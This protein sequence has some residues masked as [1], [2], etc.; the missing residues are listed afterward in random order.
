MLVSLQNIGA[1]SMGRV[2]AAILEACICVDQMICFRKCRSSSEVGTAR[3]RWNL[4]GGAIS[5]YSGAHR[6]CPSVGRIDDS[7]NGKF[8]GLMRISTNLLSCHRAFALCI[9]ERVKFPCPGIGRKQETRMGEAVRQHHLLGAQIRRSLSWRRRVDCRQAD[10][11][12][13]SLSGY[14]AF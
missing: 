11:E 4:P 9:G 5:Y 7:I 3:H 14:A 10:L 2:N 8:L 12:D 6:R 13:T 1:I